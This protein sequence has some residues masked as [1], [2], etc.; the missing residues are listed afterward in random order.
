V[1]V[2]A[3]GDKQKFSYDS[4][5]IAMSGTDR[6]LPYN[7]LKSA[8]NLMRSMAT[9]KVPSIMIR[10]TR[11]WLSLIRFTI[12]EYLFG[13]QK[14]C[15]LMNMSEN[16]VQLMEITFLMHVQIPH[17]QG[18]AFTLESSRKQIVQS[19]RLS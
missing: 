13:P 17:I 5:G 19:L 10:A 18:T 16:L 14:T 12:L 1:S 9:I 7:A 15:S 6:A 2:D 3:L 8:G 11:R 4:T